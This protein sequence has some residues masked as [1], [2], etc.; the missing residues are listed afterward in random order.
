MTHEDVKRA[1]E[2]VNVP[3]PDDVAAPPANA[4][5]TASG[6]AFIVLTPGT[7]TEHPTDEDRIAVRYAGW[8]RDG[9]MFDTSK[10]TIQLKNTKL[11]SD[12]PKSYALPQIKGWTEGVKLMTKGEKRRFWIPAEL[13]YGD[14]PKG[15]DKPAG[16]LTFDIE[17][18]DIKPLPKA[19]ADVAKPP[20]T[21]T[22]TK[23]GLAYRVLTPGT[24]TEHPGPTSSVTVHYSGW[25]TD[26]KMFDSSVERKRPATFNLEKVLAGWTEGLQL[27]VVGEKTRFWIPE[28]LAYNGHDGAPAGTLVFDIE[29]IAIQ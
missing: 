18:V 26:G 12:H 6:L 5:K 1:I 9:K 13:A 8:T 25:T 7:G 28:E 2:R 15:P 10:V 4:Q 16:P 24:G 27:M 20:A 29:L 19:P 14:V 11:L 23:S 22:H 17:L 3:A 21:A